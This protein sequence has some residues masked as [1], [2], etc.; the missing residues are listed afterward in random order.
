MINKFQPYIFEGSLTRSYP[1]LQLDCATTSITNQWSC[2]VIAGSQILCAGLSI[3]SSACPATSIYGTSGCYHAYPINSVFAGVMDK[4]LAAE[5]L[6][7]S[8][9]SNGLACAHKTPP[10]FCC[11]DSPGHHPGVDSW[12]G[13][14]DCSLGVATC[15]KLGPPLSGFSQESCDVVSGTYCMYDR[16]CSALK[17]CIGD[18]MKCPSDQTPKKFAYFD[19]LDSCPKITQPLNH[20]NCAEAREYLG[21][22]GDYPNDMEICE[23]A[24]LLRFNRNFDAVNAFATADPAPDPTLAPTQE[25]ATAAPVAAGMSL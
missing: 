15:G 17:K 8:Q 5:I 12:G 21:F 4:D 19:F 18:E 10:G 13:E 16:D 11:L 1:E 24:K 2:S 3:T 14:F 7:G 22:D 20:A 9:V 6:L 25:A 23:D